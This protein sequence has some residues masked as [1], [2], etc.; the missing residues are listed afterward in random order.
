MALLLVGSGIL[1]ALVVGGTPKSCRAGDGPDVLGTCPNV[2]PG[3][4][5]GL[6]P[7]ALA[8][9]AAALSR[10]MGREVRPGGWDG[11]LA[12]LVFLAPLVVISGVGAWAYAGADESRI[13]AEDARCEADP[14]WACGFMAGLGEG[15]F[16]AIF[17][18]SFFVLLLASSILAFMHW[19]RRRA[20]RVRDLQ[21]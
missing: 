1:I 11:W 5:F 17:A 6:V 2:P 8:I 4:L 19:R 10:V 12:G 7:A 21:S 16:A 9:P 3:L 20:V 15:T 13:R 14:N 18:I